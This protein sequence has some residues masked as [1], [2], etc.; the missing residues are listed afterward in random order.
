LHQFDFAVPEI[1]SCS[2]A[3]RSR[4]LIASRSQLEPANQVFLIGTT[5]HIDNIDPRVLRA[6]GDLATSLRFGMPDDQGYLRLLKKCLGPI[7][8]AQLFPRMISSTVCEGLPQL[9]WRG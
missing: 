8:I 9:T 5:N 2:F 7:S 3:F 4:R 1:G 6:A